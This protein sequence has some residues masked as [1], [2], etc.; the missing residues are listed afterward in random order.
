MRKLTACARDN[1]VWLYA[2]AAIAVII[3]FMN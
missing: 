1:A 3:L 2:G